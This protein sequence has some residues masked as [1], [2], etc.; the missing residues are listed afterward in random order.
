VDTW[1]SWVCAL[2]K[3]VCADD[4]IRIA[5]LGWYSY[6]KLIVSALILGAKSDLSEAVFDGH[7]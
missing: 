3:L 7:I 6:K 2:K 1:K 5:L 4:E